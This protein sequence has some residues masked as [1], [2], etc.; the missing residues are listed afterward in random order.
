MLIWDIVY[1]RLA[2]GMAARILRCKIPSGVSGFSYR[3]G[4]CQ[5]AVGEP[6]AGVALYGFQ[7]LQ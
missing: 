6:P 4:I 1:D 2:V 5:G 7:N 3:P